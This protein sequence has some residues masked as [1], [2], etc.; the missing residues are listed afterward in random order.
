M[1]RG[2]FISVEG[3]DGAGKSTQIGRMRDY[4]ADL[5]YEVVLT[6]EPGGTKISEM[7][8]SMLLDTANGEMSSMTEML[9]YASARAQLVTEIIRPAVERGA[10]VICDRF[11]DSSYVYQGFGRGIPLE[12]V[13]MVNGAALDGMIPDITLFFDLHPAVALERKMKSAQ[14]DRMEQEALEFHI[15]VYKGYKKLA[16]MYPQR[17]RSIDSS[18][19]IDTVAADV[20]RALDILVRR[21]TETVTKVR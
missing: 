19:D 20:R 14:A 7:I 21:D 11:V 17:I 4:L 10:V 13:E 2:Y 1:K 8:R 3:T 5:G 16:S 18:Q 6:R 15:R 9:L 12:T